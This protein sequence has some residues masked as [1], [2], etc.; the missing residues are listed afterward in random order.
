MDNDMQTQGSHGVAGAPESGQATRVS[1]GNVTVIRDPENPDMV[2]I[3]TRKRKKR[4]RKK[5]G[6]RALSAGKRTAIIAIAVIVALAAGLAIA[7]TVLVGAGNANLHLQSAPLEDAPVDVKVADEGDSL[8]YKGHHYVYNEN[9]V[10]VMFVGHDDQSS[11]ETIWEGAN[12][13]DANVLVA[14]DT[15]TREARAVMIPRNS[16]VYVDVYQDNVFTETKRMNLTLSYA[17]DVETEAQRAE[18]TV[19]AVSRIFY[20]VPLKYYLA[21][22]EAAVADASTAIGGVELEALDSIPGSY[23]AAGDTV[24]LMGEDAYRYVQYRDVNV[25]ESALDRQERQVQFVKAFLKKAASNGAGGLIDLYNGVSNEVCTNLG[26][27]EVSYLA[28]LFASGH[29]SDLEIVQLA[30]T[31]EEA[32]D[33][34]GVVHEHYYLDADSVTKTMLDTFYTRVD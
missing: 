21:L 29:N 26:A 11:Y 27:S 19:K 30:G 16:Y 7:F 9:I 22:D 28:T 13:A 24:L 5:S 32:P 23:Y 3:R 15:A 33:A 31:T 12:C 25:F 20:G 4:S 18:N 14:I 8:E 17:V 2:T 6:W 1:R 10:S 34:N